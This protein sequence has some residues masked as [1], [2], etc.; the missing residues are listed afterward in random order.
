M[1]QLESA[2]RVELEGCFEPL[3]YREGHGTDLPKQWLASHD[4]HNRR[5]RAYDQ[6]LFADEGADPIIIDLSAGHSAVF[7]AIHGFGTWEF[8]VVADSIGQFLLCCAALHHAMTHWGI[9]AIVDDENGFNLA[10]EPAQWLFPKMKDW[11]GVHD[12][13]WCSVF[14][15]Y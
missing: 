9:E 4:F 13:T 11:A 12:S 1:V 10:E 8:D 3:V 5:G 7:R 6:G 15:N 14:D 2:W